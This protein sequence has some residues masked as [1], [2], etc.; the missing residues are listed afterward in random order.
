MLQAQPTALLGLEQ[1]VKSLQQ[2]FLRGVIEPKWDPRGS[3]L[4]LTL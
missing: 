1:L 4:S 3:G 2:G